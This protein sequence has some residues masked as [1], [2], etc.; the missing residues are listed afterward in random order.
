MCFCIINTETLLYCDIFCIV[1]HGSGGSTVYLFDER[2]GPKNIDHTISYFNNYISK[3]P[4]WVWR[5]YLFLDNTASTSKNYFLMSWAAELVQQKRLN[6]IRLSFLIA[7][8]TKFSP[9][10][11]FSKIAQC[12]NRSDVFTTKELNEIISPY[13]DVIID[14]GDIVQDWKPPISN[15]YS[16]IPGIHSLHDFIYVTHPVMSAAVTRIRKPCHSGLFENSII[17]VIRGKDAN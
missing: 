9:D 8:H 1:N 7:G 12:Y 14:K 3:L 6:F 2:V 11:L 15:K 4:S 10:F 5:V 17:S 13:A 16:K